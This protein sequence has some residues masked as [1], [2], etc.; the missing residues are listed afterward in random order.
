MLDTAIEAADAAGKLLRR[1]FGGELQV[2]ETSLR[3]IKLEL[4][5]QAQQAITRV[6]LAEY[7]DHC[8]L[9][10]EQTSGDPAADVRWVIDP[11]DGTVNYFYNIP[12]YA[13]SIAAQQRRADAAGEDPW[14]TVAAVVFDP[15]VEELFTATH[16]Q[17]AQLNGRPVRVSD[18]AVLGEA[19]V[20]IGFFKSEKTVQQSLQVF[21]QVIGKVRKMRLQ[22]AAALDAVYVASGRYDAY[23]EHGVKLWD[24]AAGQL[25]IEQAGGR[26]TRRPAAG[27][28]AYDACMWNGRLPVEE[29]WSAA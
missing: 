25:M 9:G 19:V 21:E 7:P 5:L 13:V 10:E 16:D 24:I 22:G 20:S 12:H 3:D 2:T 28:H 29:L 6:I 17:P 27:R 23:I 18:R 11:L 8:I 1:N 26:V 15:E 4:D 14:E